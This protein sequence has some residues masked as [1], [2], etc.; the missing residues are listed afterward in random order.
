MKTEVTDVPVALKPVKK[1]AKNQSKSSSVTVQSKGK[2]NKNV[3]IQP[4]QQPKSTQ[5][6]STK[7]TPKG[8]EIDVLKMEKN[9]FKN[10]SESSTSDESWEKEFDL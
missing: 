6:Q 5:Q 1:T 2:N 4:Q 3:K 8:K 7:G 9:H 10:E